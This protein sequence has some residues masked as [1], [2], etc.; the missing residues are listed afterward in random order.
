MAAALWDAFGLPERP[1]RRNN[2]DCRCSGQGAVSIRPCGASPRCGATRF[3]RRSRI[4]QT[5][6]RILEL[7]SQTPKKWRGPGPFAK[8]RNNLRRAGRVPFATVEGKPAWLRRRFIAWPKGKKNRDDCEAEAPLRHVPRYVDAVFGEVGAVF[9]L[10]ASFF[11]VS[12]PQDNRAS[13]RCRTET[14]T[15]LESTRLPMGRRCGPEMLHTVARALAGGPVVVKSS[16]AAPQSQRI[17]VWI[18]DVRI[19]GLRWGVEKRSRVATQNARRCGAA[20]GESNCL[21]K[22]CE[23]TGAP[24][25]HETCTV[26]LSRKTIRKLREAPSRERHAAAELERLMPQSMRA[27]PFENCSN[28]LRKERLAPP[29]VYKPSLCHSARP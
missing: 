11:Q 24:L 22:K 1:P 28:N 23:F 25:N 8:H 17:C 9:D 16:C 6:N 14:G 21:T 3:V 20:L 12:L 4:H 2:G 26:R 27:A 10:K 18:G 15:L 13:F 19:G 5:T 7:A 29:N